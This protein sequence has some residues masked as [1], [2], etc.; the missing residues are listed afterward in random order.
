MSKIRLSFIYV[1]A[2]SLMIFICPPKTQAGEMYTYKDE[3]GKIVISNTPIPEKYEN[4]AKK[5]D[6][7]Q[8]DSPS[9]IRR[10]EES[11][12]DYQRRLDAKRQYNESVTRSDKRWEAN[13]D[14]QKGLDKQRA[15]ERKAWATERIED[16]E[17]QKERLRAIENRN[18]NEARRLRIKDERRQTD[19]DIQKYKEIKDR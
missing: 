6:S 1:M 2:F 9:K 8:R 13:R 19:R 17:A 3:N 18:Y 12:K 10:F 15:D 7:Y 14:R 16:L 4:K 11:Q 5:I